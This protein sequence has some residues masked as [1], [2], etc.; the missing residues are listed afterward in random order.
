[1]AEILIEVQTIRRFTGIALIGGRNP[2]E[3]AIL[4]MRHLM[5][6]H[7]HGEQTL[8]TFKAPLKWAGHDNG[9]RR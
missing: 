4:I 2:D 5:E 8:K 6:K 1:M 3:T 9:L 7:K